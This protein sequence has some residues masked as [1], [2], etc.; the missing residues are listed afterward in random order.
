MRTLCFNSTSKLSH[1]K[2][3]RP[4]QHQPVSSGFQYGL[5]LVDSRFK[6]FFFSDTKR[7]GGGRSHEFPK[8]LTSGSSGNACY[9]LDLLKGDYIGDNCRGHFGGY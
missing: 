7:K 9:R 4:L 1:G 2:L 8:P 6:T 5:C 3:F